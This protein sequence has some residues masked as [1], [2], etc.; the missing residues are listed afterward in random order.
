MLVGLVTLLGRTSF[1]GVCRGGKLFPVWPGCKRDRKGP[2][3]HGPLHGHTPDDIKV[4]L[5]LAS[6]RSITSSRTHLDP[7]PLGTL[8]I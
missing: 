3:S 2:G 5:S 8:K 4:L 6:K 7:K 1:R